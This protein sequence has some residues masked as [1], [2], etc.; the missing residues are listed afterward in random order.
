MLFK[1]LLLVY[2]TQYMYLESTKTNFTIPFA[3]PD[4]L[5]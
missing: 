1:L 3:V 5:I 4:E 2:Y